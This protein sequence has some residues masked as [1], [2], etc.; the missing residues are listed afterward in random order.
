MVGAKEYP[1]I[2]DAVK[3]VVSIK[4][5]IAP[6]STLINLYKDKYLKFKKL[7][8]ALKDVF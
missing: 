8:P 7:Y 1:S 5:K 6:N 2:E 3:K 4:E